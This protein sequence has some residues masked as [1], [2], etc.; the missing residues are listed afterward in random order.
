MISL[1]SLTQFQESKNFY[2]EISKL[3]AGIENKTFHK[4]ARTQ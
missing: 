4:H 3:Q 2:F 1:H